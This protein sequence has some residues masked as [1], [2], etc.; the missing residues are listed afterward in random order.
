[1]ARKRTK[2]DPI[3]FRLALDLDEALQERSKAKNQTP[4]E[5]VVTLL[6]NFLKPKEQK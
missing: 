5:Y 6:T 1:M 3:Q 4:T 2:G